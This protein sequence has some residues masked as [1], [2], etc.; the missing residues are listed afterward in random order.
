VPGTAS[1]VSVA[2]IPPDRAR[3]GSTKLQ[4]PN[5]KQYLMTKILNSKRLEFEI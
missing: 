4:A 5:H 3:R 1:I 2:L